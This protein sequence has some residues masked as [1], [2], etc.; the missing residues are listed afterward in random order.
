MSAHLRAW[1]GSNTVFSAIPSRPLHT[2]ENSAV[3]HPQNPIEVMFNSFVGP[4]FSWFFK[5]KDQWNATLYKQH[6]PSETRVRTNVKGIAYCVTPSN[7]DLDL[8]DDFFRSIALHHNHPLSWK[9]PV[10]SQGKAGMR[11]LALP[12]LLRLTKN[13]RNWLKTCCSTKNAFVSYV[14]CEQGMGF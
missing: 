10:A 11:I 6:K 8:K 14:V 1:G 5:G 7:G 13:F 3:G 9:Q 12:S 4:L 2:G